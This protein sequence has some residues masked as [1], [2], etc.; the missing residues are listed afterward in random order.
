MHDEAVRILTENSALRLGEANSYC[1]QHIES[2]VKRT[3]FLGQ[4]AE[5]ST[6]QGMISG[7]QLGIRDAS[8]DAMQQAFAQ[9]KTLRQ[10]SDAFEAELRKRGITEF[11]DASGRQW[12][13]EDY[14]GMV[15]NTVAQEAQRHGTMNR[16]YEAEEDLVEIIGGGSDTCD[17]CAPYEGEILS[18]TGKTPG[19]P[20]VESARIA[21]LFH[22]RCTHTAIPYIVD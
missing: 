1:A 16:M 6:P 21:G 10:A 2:M 12:D 20:T 14:C 19:Y 5:V 13:M 3:Q 8:L 18:I 9:G 17:R 15:T 11:V 7:M 4:L 22:P